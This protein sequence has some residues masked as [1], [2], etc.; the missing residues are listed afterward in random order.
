MPAVSSVT[1]GGGGVRGQDGR[2]RDERQG[3]G[4]T[5]DPGTL[6]AVLFEVSVMVTTLLAPTVQVLSVLI[7]SVVALETM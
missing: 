5:G 6:T 2:G 1:R 4:A 7:S 3:H